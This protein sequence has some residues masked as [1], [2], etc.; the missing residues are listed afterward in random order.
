MKLNIST[1]YWQ[2]LTAYCDKNNVSVNY[3]IKA[4]ISS[5]RAANEINP[6]HEETICQERGQRN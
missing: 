4:A 1:E 2:V 6:T 3:A 5:L